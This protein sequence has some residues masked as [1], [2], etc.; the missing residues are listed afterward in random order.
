MAVSSAE[1]KGCIGVSRRYAYG[2]VEA[3]AE[4]LDGARIREAQQVETGSGVK[5]KSKA[6]L[7]DCEMV[8]TS[9]GS[10]NE[11]TTVGSGAGVD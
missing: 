7:V 6:L 3:M 8:Q 4:D 9:N 2:L 11:F 1:I 5:R 10:V